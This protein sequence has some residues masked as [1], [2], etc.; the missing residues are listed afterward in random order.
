NFGVP[1]TRKRTYLISDLANDENEKN[2][3]TDYFL[4]NNLE[5]NSLKYEEIAHLKKYLRL[6]YSNEVYKKESEESRPNFTKSRE[7]IYKN[8]T[9]LAIDDTPVMNEFARTVT[10]KQDRH[11]NSG[12][13]KYDKEVLVQ[14]NTKYRNLTPRECFLLM[15]FEESQYDNLIKQNFDIG[16]GRRMLSLA[17]LIQLAGN[18]IV[19]QVLE[20]IFIQLNE[21]NIM[22]GKE[23]VHN[24]SIIT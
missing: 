4:L 14:R 20:N 18:S 22:L 9:I 12:I 6:D 7:K 11:P 16:N 21:L 19:V 15:G 8:N 13:I 5:M 2:M 10:T 24:K 23:K 3:I 1:Q 17:K